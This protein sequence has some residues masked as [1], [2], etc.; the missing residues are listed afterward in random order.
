MSKSFSRTG[1]DLSR[2]SGTSLRP[3]ATLWPFAAH[4]RQTM[5]LAGVALLAAATAT[6]AVPLAV[7]RV[8]DHG[9]NEGD[10]QLIDN[11]FLTM[12]MVV[13]VLA[14]ASSARFYFVTWLGERIVSDLRSAV[15]KHLLNLSPT[16]YDEMRTGEVVSRLTADTTQIKAAFGSG[17]SL[18]LRNIVLF[19]GATLMMVITST[20][21]TSLVLLALP[22]IIV[23]LILIGRWVRRLSRTA[24]DTLAESSAYA[25]E[26]LSGI[27]TVQ[28][29]THEVHA[30][31]VFSSHV[32]D[33]FLAAR[34]RMRARAFLTSLIIFLVFS[35]V[36]LI[37]WWGAK[38]VLT[39]EL[40]R[41]ELSQFI[42]Y[43]V[44]SAGA[45]GELSQVWGEIQLA[46][47]AAERLSELLNIKPDIKTPANPVKLPDEPLCEIAF[48]HVTFAYP[49]RSNT[50]S[51]SDLTFSV[52]PGERIAIVG[53][54]GAGKSTIFSLLLRFYDAQNGTVQIGG[55]PIQ[56]IDL[57]AA[58]SRI[59]IVPQET[60][61]FAASAFENIRFAKP[62]ANKDEVL[63][64]ARLAMADE[65]ITA[66][67]EGYHTALGERG[68]KLSG[69]QRQR[70]AIARAVLSDARIL[71]LD[72]ATNALDAQSESQ[73]Q[74]ALDKL[75]A[76]R[77][78][79]V[80][81]HRLATVQNADRI[82]VLDKGRLVAEGNHKYLASRDGLYQNFVKL[83]F[84]QDASVQERPAE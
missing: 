4:Y 22:I 65:F 34:K 58:R 49:T 18:A 70:I 10:A 52:K 53:P 27:Q 42:L 38:D 23:P 66:L 75:M 69:G 63:A 60:V 32:E 80:I 25:S 24:Q 79:L 2:P 64:A 83:Q 67:P 84:D 30:Q 14:I 57:A 51:L 77:T 62:N 1:A 15:F 5:I 20:E 40:T 13:G 26:H 41:G 76:K 8:I 19:V 55:I 59:A 61:I 11:Y 36:V 50:P 78:T 68:V 46:T 44:F 17:A 71:L 3:L 35:S 31:A 73:V 82:I 37:L 45:L 12:I 6:L 74:Q 72:E 54:S 81:A 47:G 16:F 28:A 43:A 48:D 7:R 21:L 39:G 56:N 33:S 29:F 9:F